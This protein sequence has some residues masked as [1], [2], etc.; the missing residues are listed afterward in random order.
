MSALAVAIKPADCEIDDVDLVAAVR[1][2]D[3]RAFDALFRR[4]QPRIAAY[5]GGMVRDRERAEDITQEAFM[6]AL[7]CLRQD[8]AR[9]IHFKPWIYEIAKNKCIDA[10][11]RACHTTEVSFDAHDEL[12]AAEHGRLAKPAAT[13]ETAVEGKADF[14]NL[15]GAF[16]GLSQVHHDILV[17]REF[18]GLSYREIGD[19]LDMSRGAV[20]GTLFR[21]R[22]RLGEEYEELVSGKRCLHVQR[23]VADAGLSAAG[24]RD[25]RLV[26]RHLAHCQPCRRYAHLAG[27]DIE[28]V[29]PSMPAR[30]GAFLPLP[31]FL[32][33]LWGGGDVGH[34]LSQQATRP[35]AQWASHVAGTVDPG[36]M[37]TW[38]K[39]A[40]TAATVAIAGGTTI[41]YRAPDV[42]SPPS[43]AAAPAPRGSGIENALPAAAN[44]TT[45][46]SPA[47]TIAAGQPDAAAAGT[48]PTAD[49]GG[50]TAGAK[51][52]PAGSRA[53]SGGG[54]SRADGQIR[55]VDPQPTPGGL[56]QAPLDSGGAPQI[57]VAPVVGAVGGTAPGAAP[58]RAPTTDAAGPVEPRRPLGAA[59]PNGSLGSATPETG[60]IRAPAP[61]RGVVPRP[62]ETRDHPPTAAGDRS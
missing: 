14:D 21:A 24:R 7:R 55:D 58:P 27:A 10:H 38:A 39:V 19:R 61:V 40:V 29:R 57:T 12:G 6:S 4:Y 46:G 60:N 48:P 30:V 13:P 42:A 8:H 54:S 44:R 11:R 9:E 1:A 45:S 43:A 3:D 47:A 36:T 2:G 18:E 56:P 51:S 25:Q 17:M 33:R 5:V 15:R 22:K 62:R 23:T 34:L 20:E 16:G 32:R 52:G 41:A 37:S 31:A 49:V 59:A 50:P 28:L 53:G 35:A 26:A